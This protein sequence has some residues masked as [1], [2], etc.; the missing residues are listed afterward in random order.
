[1]N[2]RTFAA[3]CGSLTWC[4]LGRDE[5][6]SHPPAS[7]HFYEVLYAGFGMQLGN[8]LVVKALDK[9]NWSVRFPNENAY[10]GLVHSSVFVH[11]LRRLGHR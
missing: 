5:A 10:R 3:R 9:L 4:Y 8:L 2:A 6:L 11:R 7:Y 1:M